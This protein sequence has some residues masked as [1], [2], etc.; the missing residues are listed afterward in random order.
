M[1]ILVTG[2]LGFIGSN[3]INKILEEFSEHQVVN[4]DSEFYGSNQKN[5]Q[6]VAHSKK[7]SYF[8]GN[9]CN[10]D[11]MKK[12]INGCDIIVNFAAESFVD[13]SIANAKPFFDS[14]TY[15]VFNI[16]EII[17]NTEKR[18]IQ[19]S[20]DEVFGSLQ[21]GTANENSVFNPSSPYAATKAS[22]ELL[23]KSYVKTYNCDCLIT[24]CTNN[25]GPQQYPEKLIP[26]VILLAKQEKKIPIYGN[27]RNVRDW[28]YVNDHCNAIID[29]MKNGNSGETYNISANN[30]VDNLAIIKNI[31]SIMN[32]SEDLIEFVEDR[33]GH[34]FRYSM[35]SEKIRKNLGWKEF[36]S[37]EKGLALT[38]N[39]Y[40]TNVEWWKELGLNVLTSSPWKT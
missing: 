15:G 18:F 23:I 12:L 9:I 6:K 10:H 13:R 34:D 36:T 16:L 21:S 32:K 24:R 3:F 14:N 29:V 17:K 7:Y 28:I 37:L 26:K 20:T 40:L 35:N 8:K 39:W 25:Y 2:G 22:A 19:I 11:L 38:V 1:K 4:V 30:E 5:V 31:L 27:G 33:P